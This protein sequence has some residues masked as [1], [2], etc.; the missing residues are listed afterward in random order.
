[1]FK[2]AAFWP[3][4]DFMSGM[5]FLAGIVVGSISVHGHALGGYL[6]IGLV[7]WILWPIRMIRRLVMDASGDRLVR[8]VMEIINEGP[9]PWRRH[10]RSREGWPG[11]GAPRRVLQITATPKGVL[12]GEPGS[13]QGRWL[14]SS[15]RP[16]R[17]DNLVSLLTGSTSTARSILLGG[18]GSGVL[19][20]VPARGSS[21]RGRA[22][23]SHHDRGEH[24]L[25][26]ERDLRRRRSRRRPAPR[27]A[28]QSWSSQGYA[29]VGRG[30]TLSGGRNSA[31][32]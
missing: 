31:S 29:L 18:Q 22:S 25:R 3:L 10:R 20:G 17:Q 12:G 7:G 28:A 19:Q 26:R 5:Q 2:N 11:P 24:R 27:C 9:R 16:A 1:V 30:V 4:T 14:R 6:Y 21:E 8:Q 32:P 15:D 13:N 23:S